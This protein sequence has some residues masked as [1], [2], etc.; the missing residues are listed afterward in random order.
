MPAKTEQE[1]PLPWG[2]FLIELDGALSEPVAL[3]CIGG[4]VIS[5]MYGLPRPTGDVDYITA[6]PRDGPNLESLRINLHSL[7]VSW[8]VAR[9]ATG[10][11]AA[12]R[13]SVEADLSRQE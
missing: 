3:H 12:S 5:M 8:S 13:Q 9:K 4:F 10:C 7:P 1:L 2:A 11:P 6:I